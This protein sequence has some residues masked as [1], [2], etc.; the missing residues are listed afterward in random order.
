MKGNSYNGT[1]GIGRKAAIC[2][3]TLVLG[4]GLAACSSSDGALPADTG[5]GSTTTPPAFT[6][7]SLNQAAY[8]GGSATYRFGHNSIP[9]LAIADAPADADYTRWAMLHDGSVYRLYL[10][11]QGTNDT[12]YQF[13]FNRSSGRYEY[14]HRSIPELKLVNIPDDADTSRFA[15]LHDGSTYRLYFRAKSNIFTMYQ[16]GYNPATQS[17]EFGRNSIPTLFITG[18]PLDVDTSRWAMLHDG[19]DYRLYLG[20]TG[21][22]DAIYQFAYNVSSSDYE[23]GY[24]SIDQLTLA[25]TPEGSFTDEFAMLHDGA[26]YRFYYLAE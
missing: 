24:R 21:N 4:F 1:P 19:S 18:A 25:D 17:Y 15:M 14:G 12:L 20:K 13:G 10:F 23:F 22:E 11:K 26:D 8:V 9:N 6:A 5:G 3:V 16:F 7:G 2:L